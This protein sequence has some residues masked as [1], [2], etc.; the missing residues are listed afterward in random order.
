[1]SEEHEEH[2]ETAPA[3]GLPPEQEDRIVDKVVDKVK[4]VIADIVGT[5]KAAVDDDDDDDEEIVKEPTTLREIENDMEAQVR[6][7]LDK[8]RGEEEAA[9]KIPKKEAERVPVQVGRVTRALWG[10]GK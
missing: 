6:D 9:E 5:P 3:A 2:E 7:A 8:I 4:G 1:M 10:D